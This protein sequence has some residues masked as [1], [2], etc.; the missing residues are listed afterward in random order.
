MQ[1]SHDWSSM[2]QSTLLMGYYKRFSVNSLRIVLVIGLD[3][4]SKDRFPQEVLLE[5]L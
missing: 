2:V 1:I 4:S 3:W 5:V